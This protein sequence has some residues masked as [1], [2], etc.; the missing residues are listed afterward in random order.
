MVEV[1]PALFGEWYIHL[2]PLLRWSCFGIDLFAILCLFAIIKMHKRTIH[3][4]F[5]AFIIGI[6]IQTGTRAFAI[7]Q[8]AELFISPFTLVGSI[9]IAGGSC[10]SALGIS[11]IHPE[12]EP[13]VQVKVRQE[14]ILDKHRDSKEVLD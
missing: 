5:S 10:M 8:G 11:G 6:I 1:F 3:P 9:G 7:M 13:V 2:T 4:L 12:A 14:F